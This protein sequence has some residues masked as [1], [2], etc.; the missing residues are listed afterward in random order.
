[1]E[2]IAIFLDGPEAQVQINSVLRAQS[3]R[4]YL[5]TGIAVYGYLANRFILSFVRMEGAK[6]IKID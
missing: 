5:L 3:A 1:M 6:E 4:G 2:Q